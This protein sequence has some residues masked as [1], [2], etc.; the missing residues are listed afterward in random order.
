LRA[1]FVDQ[2]EGKEPPGFLLG[3][4]R[5]KQ[6]NRQERT[7]GGLVRQVPATSVLREEGYHHPSPLSRSIGPVRKKSR[8]DGERGKP[9]SNGKTIRWG[10]IRKKRIINRLPSRHFGLK[11][12]E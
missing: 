6:E 8:Q 1:H 11:V 2:K 7:K 3:T 9:K 10:E 12:T 5:Y 4:F